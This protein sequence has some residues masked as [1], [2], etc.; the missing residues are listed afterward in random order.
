MIDCFVLGMIVHNNDNKGDIL[1][2]KKTTAIVYFIGCVMLFLVAAFWKN[3][4]D[5]IEVEDNIK[6][7]TG[8]ILYK[9]ED[10]VDRKSVV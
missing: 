4:N 7:V 1:M 6:H 2:K 3:E 5:Q 8:I 9:D 10:S